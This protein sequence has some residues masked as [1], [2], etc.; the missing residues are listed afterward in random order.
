MKQDFPRLGIKLLCRLFGKT[1][2]AY[3][4]HQW[5][6]QGEG[7]KDEIVLQHVIDIR[8]KQKKTGTLKLHFML[9]ETLGQHGISIGREYLFGLM[10][11]HGLAQEA[12]KKGDH[13]QFQALDA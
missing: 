9:Q 2:H 4:D 6:I 3:Y 10:R 7:L 8:K 5:R 1:R 11:D 13:Y 12:K